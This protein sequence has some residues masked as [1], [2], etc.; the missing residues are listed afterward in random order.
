MYAMS[1]LSGLTLA[2]AAVSKCE[3]DPDD[4]EDALEP[5]A[6]IR[7]AHS[8]KVPRLYK[9]CAK[10]LQIHDEGRGAL[11][12]LIYGANHPNVKAMLALLTA[13]VDHRHQLTALRVHLKWEEREPRLDP[14]LADVLLTELLWGKGR[15][16]GQSR[17]V[18]TILTYEAAIRRFQLPPLTDSV[19]ERKRLTRIRPRY[20]RIN[21]LLAPD[22]GTVMRQIQAD[23][24]S[25]MSQVSLSQTYEQF[26]SRVRDLQPGQFILDYHIPDLLVFAPGSQ[27]HDHP[28]YRAGVLLLQDKASCLPVHC[29]ALP[30]G[31]VVL[32]ACAAPGMKTSQVA[33]SVWTVGTRNG[34]CVYAVERDRQRFHTLR[35]ML[36]NKGAAECVK[37]FN[38]DF[39]CLDPAR[40]DDVEYIV[41]DPSCSGSGML[42]RCEKVDLSDE[43]LENLAKHQTRLLLHAGTFPQVRKISYSTCS[44]MDQENEGVVSAVLADPKFG[45]NFELCPQVLPSWSRR[46][47]G[48][49]R[50]KACLR[51][52]PSEDLCNGFFVSVFQRKSEPNV[53]APIIRAR[54][55]KS[56]SAPESRRRKMTEV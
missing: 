9:T 31:A 46:G 2:C 56:N 4:G 30:S 16:P 42:N 23:G 18:Q 54:K 11:K 52:D 39:L 20:V 27:F 53:E 15:L 49:E 12:N 19:V 22:T 40:F 48:E 36:Q 51:S 33:A 8:V 41:L 29:L 21:R 55:R 38:N 32:D 45:A 13:C 50:F 24:F 37:I 14:G 17:P 5:R 28:L 10:V 44:I 26:L 25:L 34:P 1:G 7:K 43:R 47:R 35:K 6:A 3:P